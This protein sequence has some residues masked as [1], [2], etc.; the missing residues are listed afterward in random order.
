MSEK[1]YR[2]S[3][4]DRGN[5]LDLLPR[6]GNIV[7][8]RII[9]D[10]QNKLGFSEAE[11]AD[12]QITLTEIGTTGRYKTT[13]NEKGAKAIK[14]VKIGPQAEKIIVERLESLSE[15]KVLPIQWIDL[16]ERFVEKKESNGA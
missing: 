11:I 10:L 2:L 6:E 13:W 12:Y 9:R 3:L 16:Y 1:S 5:L 4:K 14:I 15:K 7:T 8:L